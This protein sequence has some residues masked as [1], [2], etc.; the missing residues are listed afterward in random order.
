MLD[1][2]R[3][4]ASLPLPMADETSQPFVLRRGTPI[5]PEVP[6]HAKM[7]DVRGY[8]HTIGDGS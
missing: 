2:T 5:V 8:Y 1:D 3:H 6:L 7:K 4:L